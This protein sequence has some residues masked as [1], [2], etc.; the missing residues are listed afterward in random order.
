MVDKIS[1]RAVDMFHAKAELEDYIRYLPVNS[2]FV[3]PAF[4]FLMQN[5]NENMTPRSDGN[6]IGAYVM[7]TILALE[8]EVPLFDGVEDSWKYVGAILA[9]PQTYEGKVLWPPRRFL[10]IKRDSLDH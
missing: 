2:A 4:L 9:E 10:R 3:A 5:Y 6:E 7:A 8:T 1:G